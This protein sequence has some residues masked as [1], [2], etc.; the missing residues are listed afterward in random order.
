M[1]LRLSGKSSQRNVYLTNWG[2]D[3]NGNSDNLT[4]SFVEGFIRLLFYI[5]SRSEHTKCCM[6]EKWKLTNRKYYQTYHRHHMAC[7]VPYGLECYS[8]N[9][10]NSQCL[11]EYKL[12]LK[13]SVNELANIV[14]TTSGYK[15]PSASTTGTICP[16]CAWVCMCV[17]VCVW[18]KQ[19][20][21]A[22]KPPGHAN[23]CSSWT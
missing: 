21:S 19:S 16:L 11:W 13:C 15:I 5:H 7:L 6:N 4:W 10:L 22:L 18:D 12:S 3:K 8:R 2:L 17:W 20:L 14:K 9:S 1:L 23:R